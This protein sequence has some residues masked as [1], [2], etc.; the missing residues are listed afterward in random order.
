MAT[1]CF[2]WTVICLFVVV[3]ILLGSMAFLMWNQQ[4]SQ[5]RQ[6]ARDGSSQQEIGSGEKES[7][8]LDSRPEEIAQSPQIGGRG[9]GKT[10]KADSRAI[11]GAHAY[12]VDSAAS[13]IFVKVGSATRI[14]HLHGAEGRLKSGKISL[15][16]G[17][18]LVFDMRSF[19]A[20]TQ[21]ARKKVGLE[22]EKTSE[23]EAKKV[24]ETMLSADVLDVD[25]FPTSTYKIIATK[26]AEK[27][28]AGAPGIY[29]LNG[30]FTLHGAEQPLLFKAKLE[31]TDK[32]GVVKLSGSFAIK[33]SDYGMKPYS[34][35]GGLARVADELE[36]FGELLLRPSK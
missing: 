30:R 28:E 31:R 26:P 25:K 34:G 10:E 24:N 3:V 36:I 15:G 27:Q 2:Q 32:E 12:L 35:A 16:A 7:E 17:G 22:H 11:E 5:E 21:E 23:N 4:A 6:I 8:K 1:R 19:K 13:R 14:G 9:P 18:E 33:Q 29:E 20:D